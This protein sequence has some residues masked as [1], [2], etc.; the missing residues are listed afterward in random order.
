MGYFWEIE[1][2][3]TYLRSRLLCYMLRK[4][5]VNK[6]EILTSVKLQSRRAGSTPSDTNAEEK[7]GLQCGM[8]KIQSMLERE[9]SSHWMTWGK[10]LGGGGT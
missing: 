3:S 2:F 7:T 6:A 10:L 9:I 5:Q 4:T 8:S 1:T